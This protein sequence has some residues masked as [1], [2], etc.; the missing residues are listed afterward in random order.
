MPRIRCFDMHNEAKE[1]CLRSIS[2]KQSNFIDIRKRY[3]SKKLF[4]LSTVLYLIFI[5]F[6]CR[7]YFWCQEGWEIED[8][9][10][11]TA[12]E[13]F[14]MFFEPALFGVTGATIRIDQ[15]GAHLDYMGIGVGIIVITGLVRIFVTAFIAFGDNLNVKEKVRMT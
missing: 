3:A 6:Y 5:F 12:F 14:W 7:N 4:C 2:S 11:G 13:I 1:S 8:N 9:P 10:V 15:L